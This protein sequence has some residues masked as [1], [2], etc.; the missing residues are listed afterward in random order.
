MSRTLTI[1]ALAAAALALTVVA[2]PAAEAGGCGGFAYATPYKR[3]KV[4][5]SNCGVLGHRGTK[6]YYSWAV[7][8]PSS[9]KACL[10]GTGW[11][12]LVG[13][14]AHNG[15]REYV[16]KWFSLG[17]G[18]RGGSAVPWGNVGA[19]PKVRAESLTVPLGVPV[20]W[21]H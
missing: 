13:P 11:V 5:E 7:G 8:S 20:K 2:P 19:V 6:V 15:P 17:C 1:A 21:S 4:S 3:G 12:P 18:T 9:G 16:E 10:E 14:V